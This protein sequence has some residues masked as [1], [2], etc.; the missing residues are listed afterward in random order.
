MRWHH[1]ANQDTHRARAH[2]PLR[3]KYSRRRALHETVI[4]P[5]PIGGGVDSYAQ[6]K[7]LSLRLAPI[8]PSLRRAAIIP[9]ARNGPRRRLPIRCIRCDVLDAMHIVSPCGR[10]IG[11]H[12]RPARV[13]R[14]SQSLSEC[15]VIFIGTGARSAR[16]VSRLRASEQPLIPDGRR[17][18]WQHSRAAIPVRKVAGGSRRF[19]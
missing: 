1:T 2:I 3:D 16:A 19:R 13:C 14:S 12:G 17:G 6:A 9:L 7:S 10:R 15:C 8:R 4:D 18:S 11:P 5:P